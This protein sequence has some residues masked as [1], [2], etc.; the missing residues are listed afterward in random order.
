MP[1]PLVSVVIPVYLVERYLERCVDSVIAQ[2][3]RPLEIILVDDGSPDGCAT[4]IRRYEA[5]LPVV[6]S[7][8]QPNSGLGAAR[9]AGIAAAR[10]KYVALVDADDYVEPDMVSA[11][12]ADAERTGADAVAC[13]F[14]LELPRGVRLAVP[15]LVRDGVVTG[16]RAA[17]LSLRQRI[18][19]FAWNKLYRRD[20]FTAG[21]IEFPSGY[22]EDLATIPRVLQRARSVAITRRPYYHYCPRRSGITGSFGVLNVSDYLNALDIVRRFIV[23]EGLDAAWRSD[24]SRLLLLGE[25]Q[26]L[27]QV[28]LQ[29]NRLVWADRSR[30]TLSLRRRIRELGKR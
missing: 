12:V 8:W 4:I 2:D 7:L 5:A 14:Y 22:Y 27:L 25:A 15:L 23:E 6:R 28:W 18:P 21:G 24:Y 17:R 11:L 1:S 19:T 29:P 10:G 30:L 26:L 3:H 20:L 9:N 13:G 16:D